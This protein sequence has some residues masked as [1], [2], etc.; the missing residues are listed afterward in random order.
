MS[1]NS[2]AGH[3]ARLLCEEPFQRMVSDFSNWRIDSFIRE[4][5]AKRQKGRILPFVRGLRLSAHLIYVIREI[6]SGSRLTANWGHLLDPSGNFCSCECDV[7]IHREGHRGRWNGTQN[8]I[9]DFRFVEQ[10]RA[11]AVISVK[12]YLRSSDIDGKYCKLMKPFVRRIWLFAEC[13]GPRS[14]NN[15]AKRAKKLGY[16]K[17]WHLYTWTKQTRIECNKPG[18]NA[19]VR[20]VEKLRRYAR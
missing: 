3:H 2:L 7:I 17:F 10:E 5:E 4:M 14:G 13:C 12:S 6:L 1:N 16:S 18:W 19:F 15:I 9:M 11:I 20:E 8:P